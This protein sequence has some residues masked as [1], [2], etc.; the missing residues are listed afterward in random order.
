M[1]W[2]KS[3]LSAGLNPVCAL[4]GIE[5]G[6]LPSSPG[7]AL[8]KAASHEAYKVAVAEGFDLPALEVSRANPAIKGS[9]DNPAGEMGTPEMTMTS[10]PAGGLGPHPTEP[11][12]TEQDLQTHDEHPLEPK[13]GGEQIE[14]ITTGIG[15]A[16]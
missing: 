7:F 9:C 10:P 15:A 12:I 4:L 13:S 6:Q 14:T 2:Q 11:M 1:V 5:N 8:A 3:I 16:D